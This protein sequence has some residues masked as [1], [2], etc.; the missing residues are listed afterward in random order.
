MDEMA[1]LQEQMAE[2]QSKLREL[3]EKRA[4]LQRAKEA[5]E[6][7]K[8]RLEELSKPVQIRAES[9]TMTVGMVYFSVSTYR[10]DVVERVRATK[11]H[12]WRGYNSDGSGR[13]V[14]PAAEWGALSADLSAMPGVT[15]VAVGDVLKEIDKYLHMPPLHISLHPSQRFFIIEKGPQFSKRYIIDGIPGSSFEW[16]SSTWKVP[17]SEAWRLWKALEE[18][19]GVFFVEEAQKVIEEHVN[20]RQRLDRIA[21]QEESTFPFKSF[22]DE[23][24]LR[25]FQV[26]GLEFIHEAGGRVALCDETGLGKTWTYLAYAEYMRQQ[27]STFKTLIVAKAANIPNVLHEIQELC[28]VEAVVCQSGTP[29]FLVIG[30]IMN[31]APY[32][33]ISQDTLAIRKTIEDKEG[34]EVERFIWLGVL[35]NA[36]YDLCVIDEAHHLRNPSTKR[37]QAA[38]QLATL[39]RVIPVTA[40]PIVNVTADYWPL[41]YLVDPVT[42][43]VYEQFIRDYTYDGRTPRN[44]EELHELLRPMFLRRKKKDV[45]KDLPDINR[46]LRYHD[47]SP[48][49]QKNC[50]DIRSGIYTMVSTFDPSG[51]GGQKHTVANILAEITR[52]TQVCAADAAES[53]TPELARELVEE[54][55]DGGVVLI[56]THWLPCAY[57]IAKNLG[58]QAVTTVSKTRDGFVNMNPKDRFALYQR[59]RTDKDVRYLVLTRSG[60]EGD[61]LD[62][63]DWAIFNDLFWSPLHHYQCEGRAH[64]R[65]NNPH[66]I[67]AFYVVA[68]EQIIK[69][70]MELL[71]HKL[72]IADSAVEGV[73]LSRDLALGGIGAELIQKIRESMWMASGVQKW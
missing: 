41:L 64:G 27:D 55:P 34:N 57:A 28:G 31:G 39:P 1:Q 13:N 40:S 32:T 2:L 52:L 50:D 9:F 21:R 38:R 60:S 17:V 47:L 66:P 3:E 69:W 8:R 4:A 71:N 65:L 33:V 56:F 73:E 53:Y 22:D 35:K 10:V 30:K 19:E 70:K 67:D 63:A 49:T 42:F 6:A 51:Q 11:G 23:H 7:E 45:Q 68:G 48:E 18:V 16:E 46:I 36:G 43:K 58:E 15:V 54:H 14:V 20:R 5:D 26:N 44:V 12:G 37:S 62:F 24:I 59:T 25:R 61:N 29:D 72:K